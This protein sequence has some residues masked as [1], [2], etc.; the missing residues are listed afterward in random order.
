MIKF[1]FLCLYLLSNVA[2]ASNTEVY[3]TSTIQEVKSIYWLN[4][5]QDSAIVYATWE[6]FNSIKS[7]IDTAVLTGTTSNKLVNL[8]SADTLLLISQNQNKLL[9]VYFTSD[10]ITLNGQSYSADPAIIAKFRE[11]NKR[12]IAKGD[13]I[14]PKVLSRVIK[15]N[16]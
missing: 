1:L 7:F 14:S 8:E 9:K 12:R 3:D 11:I 6:N 16:S 4:Q 15:S 10:F 5:K 13:S 2:F